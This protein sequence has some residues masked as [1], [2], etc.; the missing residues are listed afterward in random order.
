MSP[1]PSPNRTRT[2]AP[3]C[4]I[5]GLTLD[6]PGCRAL[7]FRS[8]LRP[9]RPEPLRG[10]ALGR[11]VG[12]SPLGRAAAI[13]LDTDSRMTPA[14]PARRLANKA[15]RFSPFPSA[16]P[17]GSI[18]GAGAAS[19]ARPVPSPGRLTRGGPPHPGRASPGRRLMAPIVDGEVVEA[20]LRCPL[21]AHLKLIGER[22]CPSDYAQLLAR[23]REPVRRSAAERLVSETSGR[24]VPRGVEATAE[25]LRRGMPML[26][27]AAVANDG[28][29]VRFDA[30]RR[31]PGASRLG[32]FHYVPVLIHEDDGPTRRGVCVRG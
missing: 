14:S 10:Q 30:L 9:D 22:G 7:A 27:D 29:A 19:S 2:A 26:L 4:S 11:G 23:R 8:A 24:D 25:V 3:D 17:A 21:K 15:Y 28:F 5:F 12:C 16:H 6:G 18:A 13:R 32:E 1:S 31:V 20:F